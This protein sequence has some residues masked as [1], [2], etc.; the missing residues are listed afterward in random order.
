MI[1][2]ILFHPMTTFAAGA[3]LAL[4]V[5]TLYLNSCAGPNQSAAEITGYQEALHHSQSAGAGPAADTPEEKAAVGRFT[6]FLQNIGNPTYVRENTPRVYSADAYLNDT[7]VTRHGAAE[8]EKYFL[9]TSEILTDSKVTID[10]TSRSGGDHYIRWTMVISAPALSK[11]QPVHSIGMSQVRFNA[12]GKVTFHHDFWDSGQNFYG[13]LPV[14][15]GIIGFIRKR[16][17]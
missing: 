10:D 3:V 17:E 15:G 13:K 4:A 9:K 14:A 5:T 7:L 16:L 2:S 12:E 11:G 1:T 6:A 8:I